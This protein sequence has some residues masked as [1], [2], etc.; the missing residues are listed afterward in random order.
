MH[1]L[2]SSV[3]DGPFVPYI[4]AQG[5]I[6]DFLIGGSENLKK[7]VWSAAPE[8]IGICIVKYQNHTL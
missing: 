4:P 8:A 6:Q 3:P 1:H 2:V 7:G 5:R